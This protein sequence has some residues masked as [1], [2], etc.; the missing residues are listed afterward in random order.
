MKSSPN[1]KSY[2]LDIWNV[3]D[4]MKCGAIWYYVIDMF[5]SKDTHNSP[6]MTAS[7]NFLMFFKVFQGLSQI[8]QFRFLIKL[9]SEVAKDLIC[10]AGFQLL[11]MILFGTTLFL[12]S[13]QKVPDL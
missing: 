11:A 1:I 9:V 3:S 8:R 7:L 12:L 4:M 5:Q 13:I 6:K 2:L 10:F